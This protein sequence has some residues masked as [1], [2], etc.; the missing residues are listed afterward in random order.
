MFYCCSSGFDQKLGPLSACGD[1][2]EYNWQERSVLCF[3]ISDNKNDDYD[4]NN[5]NNNDNNNNEDDDDDDITQLNAY[6]HHCHPLPNYEKSSPH[7]YLPSL[8]V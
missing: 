2:N 5:N 6:H 8:M 7:F 4:N 3:V 1:E